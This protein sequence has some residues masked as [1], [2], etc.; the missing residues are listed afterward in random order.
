LTRWRS[1]TV[2][3][4]GGDRCF[5]LVIAGRVDPVWAGMAGTALDGKG[6]M[7]GLC[8]RARPGEEEPCGMGQTAKSWGRE[9]GHGRGQLERKLGNALLRPG[10]GKNQPRSVS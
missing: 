4:E 6:P 9:G 2:G 8:R 1:L 5:G 7:G 10:N 3:G